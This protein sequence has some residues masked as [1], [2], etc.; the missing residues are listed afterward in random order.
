F[1]QVRQQRIRE[2]VDRLNRMNIPLRAESVLALAGC[3][4]PG[5]PHVGRALVEAGVCASVDEAFERFLKKHRPAWVPKFKVSAQHA[6]DLVHEA[7]GLAV[8]AHPGL[9]RKDEVIPQLALDGLDGLECYHSKHS[10]AAAEHYLQLAQD[11]NLLVTGG[12]DCHGFS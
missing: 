5:R 1:Q 4:A 7:G 11:Y 10:P 6:I 2:M 9:N 12:S 3:R 8:L